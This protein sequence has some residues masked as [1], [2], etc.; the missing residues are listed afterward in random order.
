MRTEIYVSNSYDPHFNLALEE[1]LTES[2]KS[3]PDERDK[4]ILYLW[5]NADTVVIG[6]S[7]NAWNECRTDALRADKGTLARRTSGGGAVFHDLGN[8]C[9][10][11]IVGRTSYDLHRQLKVILEAVNSYG[12]DAVFSGRNDIVTS[13][14][15]KFSGNAFRF[16]SSAGL[17]HGTLLVNADFTKLQKYLKVSTA[18]IA[19]KGVASVRSRVVNLSELSGDISIEGLKARLAAAFINEYGAPSEDVVNVDPVISQITGC[20]V[21]LPFVTVPESVPGSDKFYEK[22]LKFSSWDWNYGQTLPFGV[23]IEKKFDWGLVRAGLNVSGGVITGV[24]IDTDAMDA[25]LGEIVANGLRGTRLS[26]QEIYNALRASVAIIKN[27]GAMLGDPESIVNDIAE[28]L[29]E[30]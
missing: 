22:Y 1:L 19:A 27:S 20:D 14:G 15:R 8:L 29:L 30:I 6:K 13:D 11:F 23:N 5:Q 24:D 25:D 18:K 26:K 3:G 16:T 10:S 7:Q 21:E 17:M 9:Y 12:I 28:M 4:A 2:V